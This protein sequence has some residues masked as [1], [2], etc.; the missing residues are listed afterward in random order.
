MSLLAA[1]RHSH[2]APPAAAVRRALLVVAVSLPIVLAAVFL[3]GTRGTVWTVLGL[4]A[5][6]LSRL[7][8]DAA[9][10]MALAVL[11]AGAVAAATAAGDRALLAGLIVAAAAAVAGLADRWSAGVATLAPVTAAVAGSWRPGL[12]WPAAGGWLLAGAGY[13]IIAVTLP[14]LHLP[15]RPVDARRAAV[16]AAALAALCGTAAGL[17]AAFRLPHGYWIVLA[18]VATLRPVV[19]ESGRRAVQRVTGTL[20]GVLVP[21]PLIYFLP[22]AA[23]APIAAA[24][25]L[26]FVS[27]LLAGEYVRQSIFMTLTI[28][29]VAS[30]GI[31]ANAI[32]ISEIRFAWTLLGAAVAAATAA[33]LWRLE[34]DW[35]R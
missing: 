26:A 5:G 29:I 30:G 1:L 23:L 8:L 31:K 10:S 6:V 21:I 20:L 19:Q 24:A 27:Y 16:H 34:S 17:A 14:N 4:V 13:G 32:A 3:S 22:P 25:I 35:P 12:S 9:R 18:L 33:I 7:V 2:P 28:V 15:P 11:T